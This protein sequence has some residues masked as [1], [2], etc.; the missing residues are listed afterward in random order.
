MGII[1]KPM[2]GR[3]MWWTIARLLDA[4]P[5]G[6][7]LVALPMAALLACW[8]LA[9]GE[10]SGAAAIVIATAFTL[11]AVVALK[12][13]TNGLGQALAQHLSGTRWAIS[14]FFPSGHVAMATVVYG[15]A[16]LCVWRANPWLGSAAWVLASGTVVGV[17]LERV[18]RA[19]HPLMD[20]VGG[21]VLGIVALG[22]LM[23]IWP[24]G[25][26]RIAGVPAVVGAGGLIALT[27][28]GRSL[29]TSAWIE[30]AVTSVRS[31][32]QIV[33]NRH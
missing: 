13:A 29:P 28:Y 16:A 31:T 10:R 22:I 6:E 12:L 15:A 11:V 24:S 3:A 18:F 26:L 27:L 14:E 4:G 2:I 33:L 9:S 17:A 19:G 23:L 20:L 8:C 30:H 5:M 32:V 25:R 1:D 21:F 7:L